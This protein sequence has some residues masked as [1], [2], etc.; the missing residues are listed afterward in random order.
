MVSRFARCGHV[1]VVV[2][3][4][5]AAML[6]AAAPAAA[7]AARP[8]TLQITVVDPSGAVIANATVTVDGGR[9]GDQGADTRAGADQRAGRGERGRPA[10]GPLHGERRVSRL[11]DPRAARGAGAGRRQQAGDDAADRRRAGCGDRRARQAG[12]GG[13]SPVHVRH[14]ADAR[15]AR[16]AL[17]R[18]RHAPAAAAGHG[19]T[20]RRDQGGQLRGRR[21]AAEGDDPFDPHLAR[22]VR[23]REPLGRRHLDRDHHPAR[24]RPDPLQHRLP[25]PRRVAERAQ[26]VHARPGAR[27]AEE[28]HDGPQRRPGA[29]QGVVQP[30]RERASTPTRRRTSTRRARSATAPAPRRCACARRATTSTSTPTSTTR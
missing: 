19:R 28:L 6:A 13:G 4:L 3:L 25:V 18:S 27:A 1:V 7:Q 17:R 16:G 20:W 9:S 29:E 15:A 11:R 14:G 23:G 22:S 12:V 2:C 26:P 10:A 24:P 30:Q 21:A 5:A 8:G